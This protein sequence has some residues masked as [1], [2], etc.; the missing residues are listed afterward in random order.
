[1]LHLSPKKC[2]VML[3][4]GIMLIAGVLFLLKGGEVSE[5]AL[6]IDNFSP[7]EVVKI[8]DPSK[9]NWEITVIEESE[10]KPS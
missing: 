9:I 6:S 4:L 1:M 2:F 3:S 8:A 10:L 5:I 7:T